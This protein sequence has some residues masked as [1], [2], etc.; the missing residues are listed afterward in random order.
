[1]FDIQH[2]KLEPWHFCGLKTKMFETL[3]SSSQL[4]SRDSG[5]GVEVGKTAV[6]VIIVVTG[7]QE[8]FHH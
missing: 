4:E 1:M 3:I 6:F 2:R 5:V 8:A 7:I